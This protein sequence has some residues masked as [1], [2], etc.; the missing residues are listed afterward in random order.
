MFIIRYE[1]EL[2]E[3][4]S[5][6]GKAESFRKMK[7]IGSHTKNGLLTFEWTTD[8]TKAHVFENDSYLSVTTPILICNGGEFF[9]EE[10]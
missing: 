5:F 7:Y 9:K 6:F 3:R 8:K 1:K 4:K 10:L 2:R